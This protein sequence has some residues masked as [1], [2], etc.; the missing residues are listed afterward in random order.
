MSL[1]KGGGG[2]TPRPPSFRKTL[3][4]NIQINYMT[5]KKLE[6]KIWGGG[7]SEAP[8]AIHKYRLHPLQKP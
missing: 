5:Y 2:L 3:K 7:G 6:E 8:L 4:K 1:I